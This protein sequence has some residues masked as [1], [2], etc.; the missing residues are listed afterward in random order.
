MSVSTKLVIGANGFLGSH[1]ARQLVAAGQPVRVLIRKGSN[2]RNI[3]DLVVERCYGDIFDQQALRAAMEGCDVVFYCVVDTRAWLRD[4][5][6]LFRTNVEGLRSVLDVA[7]TANLKRFVFTSSIVTIARSFD[8]P[9]TEDML[10]NWADEGGSYVESR[11]AAENLLLDYVKNKN[12]PGVAL[13]VANTYG[14]HDYQPTPHGALVAA[15]AQGKLP[16]FVNGIKT[17]VV[18]VEDAAR[19]LILA[20][21]KG[22]IGERY[23]VSERFVDMSDIYAVAADAGGVAKPRFRIPL[24]LMYL[25]G[26]MGNV[27]A[28]ITGRD[29]VL[30]TLSVRL[31][32]IMTAMDHSKA[33][34]ELDWHPAPI[35]DAIRKAALFYIEQG[36]KK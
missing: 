17:E 18:A 21:E 26:A 31:M 3:D 12:L 29:L 33:E 11:V 30:T 7:V 25:L 16:F 24:R 13:C 27:A 35:Q 8:K 1:V 6:P 32:H 20:A 4:P 14:P 23:I 10:F 36:K 9:A 15:A 34:R 5:A 2:T 22:R 28:K 19:A